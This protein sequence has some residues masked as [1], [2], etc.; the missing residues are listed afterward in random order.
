MP[1]AL[2]RGAGAV[3]LAIILMGAMPHGL[4]AQ[5]ACELNHSTVCSLFDDDWEF[6][7]RKRVNQVRSLCRKARQQERFGSHQEHC[8]VS[9]RARLLATELDLR[10]RGAAVDVVKSRGRQAPFWAQAATG[11]W[12]AFAT[13]DGVCTSSQIRKAH[14]ECVT[15][16]NTEF[17]RKDVQE[18]QGMTRG[19]P[20]LGIEQPE[21]ACKASPV[22]GLL[23]D[24]ADEVI[25]Q[26]YPPGDP[27]RHD[28]Q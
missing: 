23:V 14:T 6:Y 2:W 5:P 19:E 25:S 26:L 17:V 1:L 20:L 15:T 7:C 27:Q 13:E 12:S 22:M 28:R 8:V 24:P 21:F 18:L 16:C 11:Y 9:C 10:L 3:F 4:G